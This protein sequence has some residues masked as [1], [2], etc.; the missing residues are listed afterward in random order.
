MACSQIFVVSNNS[1]AVHNGI[2]NIND[3]D[4]KSL[5]SLTIGF[6]GSAKQFSTTT[7]AL[8]G[9]TRGGDETVRGFNCA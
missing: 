1:F 7:G 8:A 9:W 5:D 6:M 4:G 2:P 3:N